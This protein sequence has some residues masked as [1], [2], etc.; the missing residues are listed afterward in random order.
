MMKRLS[1]KYKFNNSN[2][3][4]GKKYKIYLKKQ[5]I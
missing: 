4:E 1:S 3:E 5:I 2:K